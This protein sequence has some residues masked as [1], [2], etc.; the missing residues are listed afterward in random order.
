M[1][2]A[3]A[4]MIASPPPSPL[5]W[6]APCRGARRLLIFALAVVVLVLVPMAVDLTRRRHE[7][8]H[9]AGVWIRALALSAPALGTAG[10]PL[11]HP[12]MVH[13]GVDPRFTVGM[14]VAP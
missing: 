11:R 2:P 7:P 5:R 6:P 13:P 4:G 10:S 8:N 14:E 1:N 9:P 3:D 12:E